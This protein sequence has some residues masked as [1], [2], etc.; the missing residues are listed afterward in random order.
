MPPVSRAQSE[1]VGVVLLTAVVVL[2]VTTAGVVVFAGVGDDETTRTSVSV[3]VTH[4]GLGVAHGGGESVPLSDLRVVVRNDSETWR[5]A[6]T[7]AGVVDG[8]DDATFEPGERWV[9]RRALGENVTT[10]YVVDERTGTVL[11]KATQ[12]PTRLTRLTR[13]PTATATA[14]P[15][16]SPLTVER[17]DADNPGKSAR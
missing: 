6:V 13:T 3:T 15:T 2:S 9:A 16:N 1:P 8:D 7:V 12:Y 14:T 11:K 4:D 5:P 17:F 10:V